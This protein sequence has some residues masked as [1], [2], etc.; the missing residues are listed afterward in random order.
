MKKFGLN[1]VKVF[2]SFETTQVNFG[3]CRGKVANKIFS[4]VLDFFRRRK[5]NEKSSNL[6]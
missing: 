2:V 6:C 4:F 5:K 3:N 1:L